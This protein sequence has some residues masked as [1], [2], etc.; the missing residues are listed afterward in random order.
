MGKKT[1]ALVGKRFGK[2]VVLRVAEPV[3]RPNGTI[4]Q[5]LEC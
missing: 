2:L 4:T 5:M 1:D 3:R